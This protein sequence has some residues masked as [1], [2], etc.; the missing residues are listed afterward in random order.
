MK[1][2]CIVA[3]A[4]VLSSCCKSSHHHETTREE[5]K[6]R[7][8]EY[9]FE[10]ECKNCGRSSEIYFPRGEPLPDNAKCPF[11]LVPDAARKGRNYY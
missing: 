3:C 1:T 7:G 4:L 11:C 5:S 8:Q 2:L 6:V 9:S 10:Y